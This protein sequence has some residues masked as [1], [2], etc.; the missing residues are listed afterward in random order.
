MNRKVEFGRAGRTQSKE[1]AQVLGP[2]WENTQP[3]VPIARARR[4]QVWM[5]DETSVQFARAKQE[6]SFFQ[7][8]VTELPLTL[9]HEGIWSV[10]R[11]EDHYTVTTELAR[12][13]GPF[14]WVSDV[15]RRLDAFGLEL[16]PSGGQLWGYAHFAYVEARCIADAIDRLYWLED[17]FWRI[18]RGIAQYT[19]DL[20]KQAL[21]GVE[22]PDEL[23]ESDDVV[24]PL[25][26]FPDLPPR[27]LKSDYG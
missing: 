27:K 6:D 7:A 10:E 23:A 13:V 21:E 25:A 3:S 9:A 8:L 22:C 17:T 5:S 16:R 20:W 12:T 26:F 4:C 18:N 14:R 2:K 1:L 11:Y 19:T 15:Q 24:N